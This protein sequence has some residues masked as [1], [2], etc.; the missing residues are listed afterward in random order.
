M[1]AQGSARGGVGTRGWMAY[2]DRELRGLCEETGWRP[3][4]VRR[5]LSVR[6]TPVSS[7]GI[8]DYEWKLIPYEKTEEMEHDPAD[9]DWGTY[10]VLAFDSAHGKFVLQHD[11]SYVG[12]YGDHWVTNTLTE[13]ELAKAY[14]LHDVSDLICARRGIARQQFLEL[15]SDPQNLARWWV[16]LPPPG[17]LRRILTQLTSRFRPN[18]Y[19]DT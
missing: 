10:Y 14:P 2:I 4:Q 3:P 19:S 8:D 17:F 12:M 11:N 1:D 13:I 6:E 16:D 15:M 7:S 9:D 5:K 18:S